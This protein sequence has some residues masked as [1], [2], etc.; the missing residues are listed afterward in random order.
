MTGYH[1]KFPEGTAER[2][3]ELIKKER[4][5]MSLKRIQCIYLRA[6]H[7]Y[8]ASL[9]AEIVG[10]HKQSVLNTHSRYFKEGEASL[11]LKTKGGRMRENLTLE[12]EEE[13]LKSFEKA[14]DD[15]QV[16]EIS[17]IRSALEERLGK[18]IAKSL[19]YSL[20]HRH[21]WR[22]VA[23]RPYHPK[24]NEEKQQAFKKTSKPTLMKQG[25]WLKV[26]DYL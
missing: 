24:H 19:V 22:K 15:G 14:G 18:K 1:K 9:I 3:A 23:P 16:L 20:L 10:F 26:K 8:S 4:D 21:G 13:F 11:E 17:G 6:K 5:A 12:Q 2:M 7:N 25:L